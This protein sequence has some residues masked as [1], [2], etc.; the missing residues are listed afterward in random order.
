MEKN[1]LI[2][3]GT[4]FI[5]RAL[6]RELLANGYSVTVLSRNPD[7]YRKQFDK[8]V[9]FVPWGPPD[10][11]RAWETHVEQASAIVNLAG[12]NIASGV[13]WS[14][15][16]KEAILQSRLQAAQSVVHAV[17]QARQKPHTLIQSSAIGFYG[18]R[19]DEVLNE[20]S[21]GGQGYLA[22]V[23]RQWESSVGS[24]QAHGVR[25]V[26]VRTG[27]VLGRSEG[28]LKKVATPF[29]LGMGGHLGNGR[30]WLSWVHIEDEVRAI[31]FLLERPD[32]SG[33]FNITAPYPL[34]ARSFFKALGKALHRP[35]W[36][37]APG[38][39]LRL[40]LGQF[41]EEVLLSGQ[42]VVPRRLEE[43]GF[44]FRYRE[45]F[46]ALQNIFR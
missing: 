33:P 43:A 31:R 17:E 20:S 13:G 45:A 44:A 12:E 21:P 15:R 36:L 34:T 8:D 41:A 39:M 30:Q 29:R 26:Y 38:F 23:A 37:H 46:P 6:C 5:G 4:G 32:L 11:T 25:C 28:F 22:D 27:I 19:G 2:T 9:V 24:L 40:L 1:I 35:S 10:T 14:T 16:K 42:R 3:G 18:N 7:I